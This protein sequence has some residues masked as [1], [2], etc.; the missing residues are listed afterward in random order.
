MKIE[1]TLIAGLQYLQLVDK[2]NNGELSNLPEITH[3]I[4]TYPF[5]LLGLATMAEFKEL[6]E[7]I[8]LRKDNDPFTLEFDAICLHYSIYKDYTIDELCD[9]LIGLVA[10][11][12]VWDRI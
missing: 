11:F 2:R 8:G 7:D 12:G 6:C 3:F 9:M 4:N 10:D 1:N 5:S